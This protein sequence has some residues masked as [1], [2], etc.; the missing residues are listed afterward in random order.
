MKQAYSYREDKNIDAIEVESPW[1]W[2]NQ[3]RI[4]CD[5]D[6]KLIVALIVTSDL[7]EEDEV[8]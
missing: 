3:F 6:K 4:V 7:P 8:F 2:W 5:Y 1:S